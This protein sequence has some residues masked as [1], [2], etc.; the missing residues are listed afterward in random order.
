M[1]AEPWSKYRIIG[2]TISK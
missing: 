1:E 2:S